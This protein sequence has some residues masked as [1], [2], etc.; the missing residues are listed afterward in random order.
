MKKPAGEAVRNLEVDKVEFD[1]ALQ[2]LIATPPIRGKTIKAKRKPWDNRP[3]RPTS[4]SS[5]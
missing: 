2:K 5:R 3:T 4:N 1:R